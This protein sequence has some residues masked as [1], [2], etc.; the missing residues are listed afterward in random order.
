LEDQRKFLEVDEEESYFESDDESACSTM[1]LPATEAEV[2]QQQV[3]SNL[4]RIPRMY[5]LS[6]APPLSEVEDAKEIRHA[7]YASDVAAESSELT[8]AG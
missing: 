6:Q 8:E 7:V 1:I 2:A 5:S 3:E 4:E